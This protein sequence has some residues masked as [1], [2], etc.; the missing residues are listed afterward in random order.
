MAGYVNMYAKCQLKRAVEVSAFG[1]DSKL[2]CMAHE[3]QPTTVASVWG[4]AM[5]M[6]LWHLQNP[7]ACWS[8]GISVEVGCWVQ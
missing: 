7:A 8:T 5:I 6:S 4:E 2:L 3:L 1:W